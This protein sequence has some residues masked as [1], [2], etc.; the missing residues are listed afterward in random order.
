MEAARVSESNGAI[1]SCS[2]DNLAD[3]SEQRLVATRGSLLPG[4]SNLFED[5]R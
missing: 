2:V 3:R 1:F 4:F 5:Y